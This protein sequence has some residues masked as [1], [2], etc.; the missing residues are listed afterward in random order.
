[1][2]IL[3]EKHLDTLPF[4]ATKIAYRDSRRRDDRSWNS[5][6]WTISILCTSIKDA[7]HVPYSYRAMKSLFIP[8]NIYV[9][10][11]R[12][13]FRIPLEQETVT[14]HRTH[15]IQ[16]LSL[17]EEVPEK[18]IGRNIFR[19]IIWWVW[20]HVDEDLNDSDPKTLLEI[21]MSCT[22]KKSHCK[23]LFA[24]LFS[25]PICRRSH[26]INLFIFQTNRTKDFWARSQSWTRYVTAR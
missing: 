8:D 22:V 2:R 5:N 25:N 20:H 16:R 21:L 4:S 13:A 24:T 9:Y 15:D 11:Q 7:T 26:G 3:F 18:D 17:Y 6:Y 14:I 10:N 19:Y 23:V 1:M 12:K